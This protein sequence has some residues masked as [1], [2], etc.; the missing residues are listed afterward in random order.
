MSLVLAASKGAVLTVW[1][2]S[3]GIGAVVIVVVGLLLALIQRTAQ[4]I[5]HGVADI[6]TEGKLT[7]NNTIQIPLFL[8]T[9]QHVSRDIYSNAAEIA[10]AA[11]GIEQHAE[12]CPGCPACVLPKRDR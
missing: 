6:W 7:A 3:L 1:A 8:R 12:G 10:V 4:E 9:T 2:V 11:E 5:E